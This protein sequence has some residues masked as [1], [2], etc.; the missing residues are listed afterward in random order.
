MAGWMMSKIGRALSILGVSSPGDLAAQKHADAFRKLPKAEANLPT[1][2]T[3][4]TDPTN[5]SNQTTIE[6]DRP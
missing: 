2:P 5:P 6:Q 4:P 1:D 3:D